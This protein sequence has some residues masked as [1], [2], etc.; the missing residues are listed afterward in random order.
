MTIMKHSKYVKLKDGYTEWASW[1][2]DY[3]DPFSVSSNWTPNNY[4]LYGSLNKLVELFFQSQ[5]AKFVFTNN[6]TYSQ[7]NHIKYNNTNIIFI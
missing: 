1:V 5:D 3:G 4:L 2:L 7:N 6:E